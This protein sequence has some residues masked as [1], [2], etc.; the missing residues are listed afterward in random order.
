M[1]SNW[2]NEG[3]AKTHSPF[4]NGK[5]PSEL[6][7]LDI[8]NS[9]AAQIPKNDRIEHEVSTWWFTPYGVSPLVSMGFAKC[10]N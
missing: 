5:S 8:C 4:F 3:K 10:H 2:A 6:Q 9:Q 1:E 7:G